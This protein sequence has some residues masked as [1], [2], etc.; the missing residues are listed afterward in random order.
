MMTQG[1][2]CGKDEQA[3]C[4]RESADITWQCANCKKKR[5]QDLNPYTHCMLRLYRLINTGCPE[6]TFP[7]LI[8]HHLSMVK[9]TVDSIREQNRL[10]QMAETMAMIMMGG[11]RQK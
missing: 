3:E 2:I 5:Y 8:W 9:E 7:E 10:N 1:L 4:E 6:K 11:K